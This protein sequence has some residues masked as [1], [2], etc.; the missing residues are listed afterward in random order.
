MNFLVD[1]CCG[2]KFA[3]ALAQLGHN[4]EFAGDVCKGA[5]DIS[6]VQLAQKNNSI[7]I[8]EDKDFGELLFRYGYVMPG[9]ILIRL[10]VD[11]LALRLTLLKSLLNDKQHSI[12]GH[13]VILEKQ[14]IRLR[15]MPS[16]T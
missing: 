6:V 15:K 10:D 11:E 14:R 7:I 2:S 5:T 9:L 13:F 3:K 4:V 16:Q 1:E 8:T 12:I